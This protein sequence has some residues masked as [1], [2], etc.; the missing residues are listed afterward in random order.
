MIRRYSFE[1][2]DNFVMGYELSGKPLTTSNFHNAMLSAL[3]RI[4]YLVLNSDEEYENYWNRSDKK[5]HSWLSFD[6]KQRELIY[7][8]GNRD[9]EW[10]NTLLDGFFKQFDHRVIKKFEQQK[11]TQEFKDE[12]K[13]VSEYY[14][15]Q[16]YF[17]RII[18]DG[19]DKI[20]AHDWERLSTNKYAIKVLAAFH[21]K[22]Q[23]KV[24]EI[25]SPRASREITTDKYG[26]MS[27]PLYHDID[28]LLI[29]SSTEPIISAR[30]G[31]KRYKVAPVG[32]KS[33]Q[34]F[35]IEEAFLK[36]FRRKKQP[37]IEW[38]K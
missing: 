36:K 15:T 11:K 6:T 29:L 19:I 3:C 21:S 35:W 31:A 14:G 26:R 13:V 38:I 12:F 18:T 22:P 16:G 30:K 23:F 17:S 1:T 33:I 27:K 20:T 9:E 2:L 8:T 25:V 5:Y 28:K 37:M 4:H 32:G 24:G 10:S 34:P 7:D